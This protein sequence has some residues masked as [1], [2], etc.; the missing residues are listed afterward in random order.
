MSSI[1]AIPKSRYAER[2][3]WKAGW[4]SYR[5][6]EFAEAADLFESAAATFPRADNRPAWLYWA[7]RA[8][9]QMGEQ[10][11]AI[12]RYRLVVA[13]Y[14]NS[15]YGREAAKRL[16]ARR[17][18]SVQHVVAVDRTVTSGSTDLATDSVIRAL[19]AAGLY[20]DALREV[21]YAQRVWG[22]SPQ[23]CRRPR[24]GSVTSRGSQLKADGALH[25]AARR[26]HHDAARLSAVHGRR[27]RDAAAGRAADHLPAR[28]LA[29]HQEVLGSAQARPVSDR[30]ADGAGVDVHRGDPLARQRLRPDA[31]DSEHGPALRAQARASGFRRR[32]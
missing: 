30:G 11:T 23:S 13:D 12:A 32:R 26:D 6:G 4:W 31:D 14:Q 9:E 8:R 3:A 20:D 16:D 17:E 1:A 5:N 28:L 21:Q 18:P 22:D 24:R 25:R 19:A 2:A 7:A 27:R 15:Y 10:T 29:A